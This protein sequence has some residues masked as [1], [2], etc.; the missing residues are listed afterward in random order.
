MLQEILSALV[1]RMSAE[2]LIVGSSDQVISAN[3]RMIARLR[4]ANGLPDGGTARFTDLRE[5]KIFAELLQSSRLSGQSAL[6]RYERSNDPM[7]RLMT[8]LPLSVSSAPN[9]DAL[10]LITVTAESDPAEVDPEWIM[11]LFPGVTRAEAEV[12]SM[13]MAGASDS[14]IAA[15][16]GRSEYTVRNQRQSLQNKVGTD[17]EAALIVRILRLLPRLL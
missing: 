11:T 4:L 10:M 13:R 2:V 6:K 1:E 14:A 16:R 5:D 3:S 7:F 12:L 17:N 15:L 9:A 8:V